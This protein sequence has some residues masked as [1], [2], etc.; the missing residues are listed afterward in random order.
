MIFVLLLFV[1][2]LYAVAKGLRGF[3][4]CFYVVAG[5]F[6]ELKGILQGCILVEPKFPIYW[7]DCNSKSDGVSISTTKINS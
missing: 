5:E 4:T 6:L 3:F 2:D 7:A 1:G